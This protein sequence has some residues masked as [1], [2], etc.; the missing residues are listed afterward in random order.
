[1]I[2]SVINKLAQDILNDINERIFFNVP[3]SQSTHQI[4]PVRKW[5]DENIGLYGGSYP[6]DVYNHTT[7]FVNQ[8]IEASFK[9]VMG[10]TRLSLDYWVRAITDEVNENPEQCTM[11]CDYLNQ[12][13]DDN[14]LSQH[15]SPSLLMN[16]AMS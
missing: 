14:A 1:M 15:Y 10:N 2:I 16:F 13:A 11:L 3:D 8:M 9:R 12:I 7:P 6:E 4:E 5:L